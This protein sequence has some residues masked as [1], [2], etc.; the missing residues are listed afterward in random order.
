MLDGYRRLPGGR[1]SRR[2]FL[3]GAL[4]LSG[5]WPLRAHAA[6]PADEPF[7]FYFPTPQA[8]VQR[9]LEL[10][11]VTA[12]DFVIDLGS[13]DGRIVIAAAKQ[14]GARGLGIDIDAALVEKS[15]AEAKRQKLT[16][17]VR[18]EVGDV[19]A[20][21]LTRASVV[22]LF[23]LPTLIARVQPKLLSELKPGARIV[24][25]EFP[26]ADWPPDET[27]ILYA[28]TRNAGSGGDST[29]RLWTVPANFGGDWQGRVD[30]EQSEA[31]LFSITQR[32]QRASGALRRGAQLLPLTNVSVTGAAFAFTYSIDGTEHHVAARLS[33]DVL[34]GAVRMQRGASE[35]SLKFSARRV[36]AQPSIASLAR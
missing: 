14:Y 7:S 22:T 32:Y 26:L 3:F 17:R 2:S 8:T 20:A 16:D 31:L 5:A 13:G 27:L 9:M 6:A 30:G 11:R 12:D 21:D 28:P 35:H 25:H 18:F 4:A 33:G 1:V 10:A 36:S 34:S 29:L 15:I 23:L 24:T 19:V